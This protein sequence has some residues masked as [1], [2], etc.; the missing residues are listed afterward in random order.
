M[1]WLGFVWMSM[2]SAHRERSMTCSRC[3]R[4]QWVWG[5][6]HKFESWR[7]RQMAEV[8]DGQW[9][10]KKTGRPTYMDENGKWTS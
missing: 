10:A 4:G 5:P 7:F 8:R 9:I 3:S 6:K 2:C 1:K